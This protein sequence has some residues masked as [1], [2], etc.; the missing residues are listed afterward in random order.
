LSAA[1]DRAKRRKEVEEN[2][3]KE[4]EEKGCEESKEGEEAP[5]TSSRSLK[6][7]TYH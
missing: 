7:L 3:K 4:S 1:N 2:G 6:Q 5:L